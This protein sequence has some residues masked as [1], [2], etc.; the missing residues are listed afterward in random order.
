VKLDDSYL[1]AKVPLNTGTL[2]GAGGFIMLEDGHFW[3]DVGVSYAGGNAT[4]IHPSCDTN[5]STCPLAGTE[6]TAKVRFWQLPIL[7]GGRLPLQYVSATAGTGFR[8]TIVTVKNGGDDLSSSTMGAHIPAFLAVE[9]RPT[10]LLGLGA[11]F[12]RNFTLGSDVGNFDILALTATLH[13]TTDC[14][15]EHFGIQ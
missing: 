4:Y 15:S 8:W 1:S 6:G 2:S 5:L 13:A 14:G 9:G 7:V 12:E 3:C 11:R 10:C